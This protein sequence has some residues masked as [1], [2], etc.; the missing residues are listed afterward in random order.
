MTDQLLYKIGLTLIPGVGDVLGK[1]L[2]AY[3]GGPEAVFLEK[4]KSL[5]KIPGIGIQTVRSI[6]DHNVLHRAEE[7]LVFI[8]KNKIKPLFYLDKA[9][10]KRL[11]HCADSPLLVYYL[12]SADLNHQHIIGVVGTR[13]ATEYGKKLCEQLIEGLTSDNI[14]IVSGLAYGIDSCA[15]RSAVKCGL[16]TVGVLAHGLDRIYPH[17]NRGL[18]ERMLENGGLLTEFMSNTNPDRENFPRRN[19]IVAGM[20]DALVVVESA[21]RG[22]ALITADI[23]NSYNRDVFAFPGRIGDM[24]SEGCNYFIRTN[25]AVLIESADD[26]RYIMGWDKLAGGKPVQTRLFREFSEEEQKIIN[27]FGQEKESTIDALMLQSQLPVSKIA[28]CL[29]TLEF[30]GIISALPGKRY[31]LL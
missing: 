13:S 12:G 2:V 11:Q 14:M 22:G 25:R 7:E 17:L 28:A 4:R 26:I 20:V 6:L 5:E 31:K 21:K 24:Y 19:R 15:H 10:P 8:D 27:V 1:K 29:L 16:P 18:A 23:A 30:D 3:C 9:Y